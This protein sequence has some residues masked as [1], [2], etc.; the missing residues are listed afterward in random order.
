MW[1]MRTSACN[2]PTR[3]TTTILV[4]T[5]QPQWLTCDRCGHVW[6]SRANSGPPR[7]SRC[8]RAAKTAALEASHAVTHS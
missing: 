4:R 5:F 2:D 1:G 8:E 7:C 3:A 6:K